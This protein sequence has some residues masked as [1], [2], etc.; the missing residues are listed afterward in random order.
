MT[1]AVAVAATLSTEIRLAQAVSE[2]VED[3][4]DEQKH[5]YRLQR[6]HRSTPNIDDV[7]R[8]TAEIDKRVAREDPGSGRVFGPRLTN[9][10]LAIQQYAA[11]GDVVIGGS[12]NLIAFSVWLILQMTL[13]ILGE[14]SR[15]LEKASTLFMNAGRSAPCCEEI[16]LPLFESKKLKLCLNEYLI[17]V[18][19]ICHYLVRLM[20]TSVPGETVSDLTDSKLSEFESELNLW[21]ASY[22]QQVKSAGSQAFSGQSGDFID[23][24][25]DSDE[26][27]M[28]PTRS[29][30]ELAEIYLRYNHEVVWENIRRLGS[31]NLFKFHPEYQSF[32]DCSHSS[33][34]LYS[35]KAG[36]GKSLI[37]A[38]IVDDLIQRQRGNSQVAYF[39][40]LWDKFNSLQA[41]TIL[42][43]L[44]LQLKHKVPDDILLLK[45]LRNH[46]FDTETVIARLQS[47]LKPDQKTYFVL[48]GL[49]MCEEGERNKA[50]GVLR[51][52]QIS[53][54]LS[55]CLSS[56][57]GIITSIGWARLHL[58]TIPEDNPDVAVYVDFEISR[59][60]QSRELVKL[61]SKSL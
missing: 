45:N 30:Q 9:F 39:F 61:C 46:S 14:D 54:C 23:T 28:N 3:L 10:I 1:S 15:L 40:C 24:L 6:D 41:V 31:T 8:L 21:A 32:I 49:D 42:A 59:L 29:R 52:L 18:I 12:A 57:P 5:S 35:G 51:G 13:R 58:I 55:I 44:Y 50:I 48:D 36:A 11:R 19:R 53:S 27:D 2:F 26:S 16:D 56:R 60:F 25:S 47:A 4:S 38:N 7:M 37:L 17:V 22:H 34:L 43:S 20:Q 33:T